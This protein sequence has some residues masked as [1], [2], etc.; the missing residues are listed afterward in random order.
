MTILFD[1]D[2]TPF[3]TPKFAQETNEAL[4]HTIGHSVEELM[5]VFFEYEKT[6]TRTEFNPWDYLQALANAFQV[7][8]AKLEQVYFAP[9]HYRNS[10]YSETLPVLQSLHEHQ[11]GAYTEAVIAW[12]EKK[13]ELSGLKHFFVNNLIFISRDKKDSQL[14]SQLPPSIVID[15]HVEYLQAMKQLRPNDLQPVW[16]N[17]ESEEK[18]PEFSTIHDLSEL[19]EMVN[20]K[21]ILSCPATAGSGSKLN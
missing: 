1:I 9:E 8:R 11:L 12:Q 14:I 13:L 19:I 17:R 20:G 2:K 16:I 4:A 6:I 21:M 7:D 18:S 3:D 15:D 10:L 5:G